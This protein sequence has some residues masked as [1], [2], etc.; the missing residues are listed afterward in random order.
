MVHGGGGQGVLQCAATEGRRRIAPIGVALACAAILLSGS[1]GA[2][3]V[4]SSHT[5]TSAKVA[6]QAGATAGS[7][8]GGLRSLTAALGP[9]LP[10]IDQRVPVLMYHHIMPVP[11]NSIAISPSAFDAQMGYL[12]D[13][14]WHAVSM[15]QVQAFVLTGERLPSKPVLITF[16]DGR[17]N[18]FTYGVPILKKY[19]F[20]AT[21]FV[22][23]SWA[24]SSDPSF[25]HVAQ[26]EALVADGFDVESH[27]TDHHL[28]TRRGQD[29]ATMKARLW[30]ATNGMRMWMDTTLGG[31]PVTAIA[32]PG[33]IYDAYSA[34][35]AQEA[36][37]LLAFTV[38]PGYVTYRGQSPYLLP[39]WNTGA[40][41][42]TLGTFISIVNGTERYKRAK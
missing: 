6:V 8:P 17:M 14:G 13:H 21:F 16:D 42:T 15:A 30:A 5:D 24:G 32:Y 36:G 7:R 39:R 22:V 35:L 38:D 41:G 3:R 33:G 12:H 2:C 26:L 40:R 20:T 1:V 9:L 18:Q 34:R 29:Y 19:G 10:A 31:A 25:M 4:S 27:T 23:R 28:L 37:Y 11:S